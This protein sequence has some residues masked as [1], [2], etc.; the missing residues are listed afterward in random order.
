MEVEKRS[1]TAAK[2]F[3]ATAI[4]ED[5]FFAL[6]LEGRDH[7]QRFLEFYSANRLGPQLGYLN[8]SSAHDEACCMV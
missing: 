6:A 2:Y 8:G 5:R 4:D 7:A 3:G 1:S